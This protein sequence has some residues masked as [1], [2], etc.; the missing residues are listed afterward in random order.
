ME[1]NINIVDASI[2]WLRQLR[3]GDFPHQLIAV[4]CSLDHARQVRGLY[5]ERGLECREI[6]SAMDGDEQAQVLRDLRNGVLDAVVQVQMLGE[7][8]DHPPL[9][10]AAIFRPYRSLSPYIQ[11]VGRAM[12]VNVP[13]RPGHP[14]NQ[15][16]VVSHIG[17]N[18]DRHWNDFKLI[19]AED[20][21][22]IR[23]WLEAPERTP[24][25]GHGPRRRLGSDM[26]V[27][28]EVLDRFLSDPFLDPTDET[29][30]DNIL[31]VM[32]E[33]GLDPEVL[34]LT[35]EDLQRRLVASRQ[36]TAP[37]PQRLPVQPQA[38][39]QMLRVR[40]REQTQSAAGRV[41][42]AL[43]Q[44]PGGRRIALFGGTGATNNLGAVIVLMNRA[45]N[46]RLGIGRDE[47]RE[48]TAEELQDAI[49]A[50]DELADEVQ[51]R[52]AEQLQG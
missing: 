32:R 36:H 42:E 6:H 33:Q 29:V 22:L 12:R 40:L 5:Q 18:I 27:T 16:V 1:S 26:D 15:G 44:H 19:D 30:I 17:L 46:D 50:L 4:A 28:Q 24:E 9:S 31:N 38:H 37:E 7:G 41:C 34:G 52:L 3:E 11:F 23:G 47:R 13:N 20:Q 2:Q 48:R 35:R 49:D 21:E 39:R 45:V 51:G 8:F 25:T 43:G 10:V 14:D